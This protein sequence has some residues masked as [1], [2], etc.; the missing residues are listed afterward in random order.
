MRQSSQEFAHGCKRLPK[1]Q[2]RHTEDPVFILESTQRHTTVARQCTCCTL[3]SIHRAICASAIQRHVPKFPTRT[4]L[5]MLSG[6]PRLATASMHTANKHFVRL[7]SATRSSD[8]Q[9]SQHPTRCSF[10]LRGTPDTTSNLHSTRSIPMT[11]CCTLP[12]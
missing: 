5:A 10:Y 9:S 7:H 2:I 3:Q 11:S 6:L 4:R 12:T 8:N 1:E